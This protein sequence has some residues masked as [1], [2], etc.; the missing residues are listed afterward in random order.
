MKHFKEIVAIN[1]IFKDFFDSVY[2]EQLT[3]FAGS[4]L[5]YGSHTE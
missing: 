4:V 1:F 2:F 3:V 5:L